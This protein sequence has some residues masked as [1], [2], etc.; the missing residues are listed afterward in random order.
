[1]GVRRLRHHLQPYANRVTLGSGKAVV[2]GPA[3][4]YH[5]HS[6]CSTETARVPSCETLGQVC[7]RWLDE[8]KSHGLSMQVQT[9]LFTSWSSNINAHGLS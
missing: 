7:L 8:V 6:L 5:I 4:A 3:L 2:D 1:M 9:L